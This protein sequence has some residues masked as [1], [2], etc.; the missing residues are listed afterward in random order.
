[1]K[2]IGLFCLLCV[3][4]WA[5]A[6][7]SNQ[8]E[9]KEDESV[10]PFAY[11]DDAGT[12]T[13]FNDLRVSWFRAQ[14]ICVKQK[15]TLVSIPDATTYQAISDFLLK[16]PFTI[17]EPLWTSGSN[18]ANGK[19]FSWFGIYGEAFSYN[20]FAKNPGTAPRCVGIHGFSYIWTAENC[21]T[22]RYFICEKPTCPE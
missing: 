2:S 15:L 21:S 9:S 18:L 12:Y 8:S 16:A 19:Q 4:P 13:L 11:T 10:V 20:K 1:M 17:N 5:Q 3:V 14:E 7:D 22:N 6:Q